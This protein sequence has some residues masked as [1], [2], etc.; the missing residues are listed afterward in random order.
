[1]EAGTYEQGVENILAG[2]LQIASREV[3]QAHD[4][5]GAATELVEIVRR[6]RLLCPGSS[7]DDAGNSAKYP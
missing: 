7:C 4:R 3:L 6:A 5:T 1:M 2:S